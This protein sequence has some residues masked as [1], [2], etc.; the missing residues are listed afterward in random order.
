MRKASVG[1]SDTEEPKDKKK[2]LSLSGGSRLELKK[3][4]SSGQVRQS[5]SHGRS[6]AV[7]VEVRKKR[8]IKGA[9]SESVVSRG[10]TVATPTVTPPQPDNEAPNV[11]PVDLEVPKAAAPAPVVEEAV[12]ATAPDPVAQ[13]PVAAATAEVAPPAAEPEVAAPVVE[14]AAEAEVVAKPAPA[15]KPAAPAN[16]GAGKPTRAPRRDGKSG[17][18]RVVLKSLTDDE[19]RAR[20]KALEGAKHADDQARARSDV[21]AQRR[22]DEEGRRALEK[23]EAEARVREEADRKA[24][25]AESR[26]RAEDTAAKRL[27]VKP[28]AEVEPGR[29]GPAV[30]AGPASR[31]TTEEEPARTKAKRPRGGRNDGGNRRRGG[32]KLTISDALSDRDPRTR[33]LAAVKRARERERRA[34]EQEERTKILRDVVIPESISVQELASRMAERGVDV[35]KTM[36]GMGVMATIN[37]TLDADTAELVVAEFGH[38]VKRVAD[39]D[40]DVDHTEELDDDGDMLPRAP[41]VTIMGHVDH[42]KTSLLDALRSTDVAEGEAGGI[43][44]HIGAYQVHLPSG[45]AIT[46][47]DTPGHEA[48]SAMRARGAESTDIVVLVVAADDGIMPQTV[49][50]IRHAK[51]AGVPIIVAINKMDKPDANPE[52]VRNELLSHEILLESVGG[53][54]L[55]VEVSAKERT[56]L[57]KLEE[58]ILLQAEVLELKANPVRSASGVVIEAKIDR[59]RGPVATILVQR[60]TLS[61]GDIFVAGNESGRV[62]ALIDDHGKKIKTAGPSVP[63]EVLGLNGAP[64]AGDNFTVVESEAKAR[65]VAEFR[66]RRTKDQSAIASPRNTLEQMFNQ[67]QEGKAS[68]FPVVIKADVQ[69]SLEAIT[70]ALNKFGTDEVKIRILHGDVGAINESDISLAQ[71]SSALVIAFNVRANNQARD[72]ARRENTEIRY[73]SVIYDVTDDM[74]DILSGMLEPTRQENFIGNAEVKE[75]FGVSKIGKVAGCLVT[76][77]MVKKGAGVRLLRDNVVVHEGTLSTLRRFKDDV[78]EVRA[79]TECGMSFENYDDIKVGDVIEAFEVEIIARTL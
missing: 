28:A 37:D 66:T 62:R 2:S 20:L 3:T 4:V 23:E 49:E 39:A 14:V 24:T 69:G 18:G 51:A 26:K 59:G 25:E 13:E 54:V 12:E 77:G 47:L 78:N 72:M 8:S 56:G 33:S 55:S 16:R 50:A 65:E 48:F 44:Q 52:R 75:V 9:K 58:A 71:A 42:G 68:E 67:I 1:M 34:M 73:Y 40:A 7:T 35:I 74:K 29:G 45:N 11:K 76:D 70:G 5:F 63:V 36:M 41:V 38:R 21:L 57:D 6:K 43:T 32:G 60:G 10:E 46:F 15:A 17:R 19:K 27:E 61:V 31:R 53:D 79:G 30:P 64:D 22:I